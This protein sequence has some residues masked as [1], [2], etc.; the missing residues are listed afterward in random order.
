MGLLEEEIQLKGKILSI[1]T[2]IVGLLFI[3]YQHLGYSLG[4]DLFRWAG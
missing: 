2:I 4:D 1:A 3:S